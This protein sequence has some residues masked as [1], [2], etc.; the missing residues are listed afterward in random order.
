MLRAVERT[1]LFFL[2]QSL[3]PSGVN[4]FEHHEWHMQLLA[5]PR[6]EWREA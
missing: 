5:R 4:A 6:G 1:H 3:E 2:E